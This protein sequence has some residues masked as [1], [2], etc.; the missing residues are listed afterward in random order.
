MSNSDYVTPLRLLLFTLVFKAVA[1]NM[2]L[3][4]F[5]KVFDSALYYNFEI[6]H[7]E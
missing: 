6:K 2:F 3:M 4:D 1:I 5:L 7:N